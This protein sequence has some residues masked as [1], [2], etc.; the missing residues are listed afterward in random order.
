MVKVNKLQKDVTT[1]KA[2]KLQKDVRHYKRVRK[3]AIT[4]YGALREGFQVSHCRCNVSN[5]HLF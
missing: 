5:F 1:V 2:N 3:D 4:L